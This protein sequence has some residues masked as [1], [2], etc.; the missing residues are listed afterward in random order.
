MTDDLE[1]DPPNPHLPQRLTGVRALA[2]RIQLLID[3]YVEGEEFSHEDG[4]MALVLCMQNYPAHEK[5]LRDSTLIIAPRDGQW[6]PGISA[7]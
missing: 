1:L 7:Q 2:N 3:S 6:S 5:M 4:K